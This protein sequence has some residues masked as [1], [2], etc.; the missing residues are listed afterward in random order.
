MQNIFLKLKLNFDMNFSQTDIFECF[1]HHKTVVK[2][3][4]AFFTHFVC[5]IAKGY[6]FLA[7]I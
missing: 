7:S 2:N 1:A 4:V 5:L 6:L 3:Y